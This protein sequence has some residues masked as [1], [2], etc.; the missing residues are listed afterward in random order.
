[1]C[2]KNDCFRKQIS[3]KKSLCK[4]GTHHHLKYD[5]GS[6]NECSPLLHVELVQEQ[7]C[8][9]VLWDCQSLII[10]VLIFSHFVVYLCVKMS[11]LFVYTLHQLSDK[12]SLKYSSFCWTRFP[13]KFCAGVWFLFVVMDDSWWL[14]NCSSCRDVNGANM[15]LL[16]SLCCPKNQ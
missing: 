11:V 8:V 7:V 3:F 16:V 12:A 6:C 10:S 2:S 5:H 4:P 15:K 14:P 1:M 9:C 13:V